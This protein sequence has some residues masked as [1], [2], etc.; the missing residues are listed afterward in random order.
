MGI[1]TGQVWLS[2]FR[3]IFRRI[4]FQVYCRKF[5]KFSSQ[6][7]IMDLAEIFTAEYSMALGRLLMNTTFVGIL[8]RLIYFSKRGGSKEYLLSYIA[9]STIIFIICIL[10]SQVEVQLG[11]AMG[12]FA[13]FSIIRFRNIQANP[14][15]L[16][17]LFVSLGL[18]LMNSLVPIETPLIR[19][20]LNNIIILSIVGIADY[21]LFRNHI[22]FK[23]INYDR[24]DLMEESKR[25]E[26]EAD[27]KLRFGIG[28][29]KKIQVGNV[30]TIKGQVKIKVWIF[31]KEERHYEG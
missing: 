6:R 29:I 5:Y 30:D 11:I 21:L 4:N 13:V 10:L 23:M 2:F 24:L 16:S 9:I 20:V 7:C 8:G 17:F 31:D 19:L 3:D 28:H 14:R 26:M 1:I 27:L 22:V 18:A 12:L 15:E 25:G